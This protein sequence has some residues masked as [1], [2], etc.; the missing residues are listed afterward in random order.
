VADAG[1]RSVVNEFGDGLGVFKHFVNFD[2]RNSDFEFRVPSTTL[3]IRNPNSKF[4]IFSPAVRPN[5]A[6]TSAQFALHGF[7]NL[8]IGFVN[9]GEN[10]VLK[11]F[12]IAFLHGFGINSQRTIS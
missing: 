9:G 4:E 10:H 12:D 1:R 6:A 2:F 5:P 7:V 3:P 11:H 8:A